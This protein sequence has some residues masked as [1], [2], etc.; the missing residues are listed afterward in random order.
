MLLVLVIHMFV[1]FVIFHFFFLQNAENK[2]FKKA[3]WV[4]FCNT[5]LFWLIVGSVGPVDQQINFFL[6]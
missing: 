6:A 2:T 4:K 5:I 1:M 3:S